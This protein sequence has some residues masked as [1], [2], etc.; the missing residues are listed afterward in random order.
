[1]FRLDKFSYEG[2]VTDI[3]PE[4]SISTLASLPIKAAAS[5]ARNR[6]TPET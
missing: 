6:L 1:L 3:N 5:A 2:L 4:V